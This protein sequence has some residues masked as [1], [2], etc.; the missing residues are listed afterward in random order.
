[1]TNILRHFWSPELEKEFNIAYDNTMQHWPV[2]Y[3]DLF[4]PTPFG[5]THVVASGQKNANPVILL[6]PGGGS[7]TIWNRNIEA[8]CNYFRVYAVDVIGEMNKSV[9]IRPIRNHSDFI[10]W[11]NNL[12]DGLEIH[13][14]NIIGNSNGGFFALETAYLL[15]KRTNKIVL[16]SP[17]AT[18]VQMWAFWWKLLTPAH[19]I[20][21]LICS[22]RMV[23]NAY[24]WLWQ[25]FPR[26]Q[27][28]ERL[29][30]I[31]VIAGYPRYRPSINSFAPH[32]FSDEE[33]K[34]IQNPVLLLIGDHEVIYESDKVILRAGRLVPNLKA[35]IVP[36]AN[37]CAQYTA[38]E[39]VN[40]IMIEFLRSE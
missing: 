20:A 22:E 36:N 31:A 7:A 17:A 1:M 4:V 33:L 19:V 14:A 25:G 6:N 9:P 16:I 40:K 2:S 3:D 11:M 37:H 13:S 34:K 18:F 8:L 29:K 39:F 32:V 28:D 23:H 15:P 24:D 27:S 38:P 5:N 21:P 12:L 10:L 30:Y 35:E 26:E